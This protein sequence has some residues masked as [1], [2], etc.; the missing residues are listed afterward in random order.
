M[1]TMTV[2]GVGNYTGM[3]KKTFKIVKATNP[4]KV[5]AVKRTV[6]ASKVRNKAQV[7]A[8][9]LKFTTKAK[10]NANYKKASKT[11]TCTIVVK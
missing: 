2:T 5:K 8:A 4:M 6:K 10:G 1:A 7:V 11:I 3:V 9:P